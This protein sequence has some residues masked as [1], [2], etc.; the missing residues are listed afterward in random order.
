M[1]FHKIKLEE[2][3][4]IFCTTKKSSTKMKWF[5]NENVSRQLNFSNATPWKNPK[6]YKKKKRVDKMSVFHQ[7]PKYTVDLFF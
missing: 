4:N 1:N 2:N 7:S 3:E 6:E 5:I